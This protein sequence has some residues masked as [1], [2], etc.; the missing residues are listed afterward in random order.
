MMKLIQM[1]RGI[2]KAVVAK[3]KIRHIQKRNLL[4]ALLLVCVTIYSI[5]LWYNINYL[6]RVIDEAFTEAVQ[7]TQPVIF[8]QKNIPSWGD[9]D[10]QAYKE[11]TQDFKVTTERGIVFIP[12][13]RYFPETF[14][15]YMRNAGENVLL[16]CNQYNLSVTDS[17]FANLLSKNNISGD[18]A[19]YIMYKPLWETQLGDSIERGREPR[20]WMS[21]SAFQQKKRTISTA[22][23]SISID[24]EAQVYAFVTPS[25]ATLLL[26]KKTLWALLVFLLIAILLLQVYVTKQQ[27]KIMEK[28]L[29]ELTKQIEHANAG[30]SEKSLSSDKGVIVINERVYLNTKTRIIS[31]VE[32]KSMEMRR[33]DMAILLWLLRTSG[34]QVSIDELK[35]KYLSSF[36]YNKGK[37]YNN[38]ISRLRKIKDIDPAL[39]LNN[40]YRNGILLLEGIDV[41]DFTS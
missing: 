22:P 32:G 33:N 6:Q 26:H 35:E 9:R 41:L 1:L 17:L 11:N 14:N 31:N 36:I 40:D 19:T 28:E 21:N 18:V 30:K 10:P 23:F 3:I 20:G 34:Y 27:R 38:I 29:Q 12:R 15:E 8:E 16:L 24:N 37:E 7:Q 13:S 5:I 25:W 4:L 39:T 2:F